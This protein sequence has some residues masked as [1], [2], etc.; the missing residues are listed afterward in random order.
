MLYFHF[1]VVGKHISDYL[2]ID[3]RQL[4]TKLNFNSLFHLPYDSVWLMIEPYEAL[5]ISVNW[6]DPTVIDKCCHLATAISTWYDGFY[7]PNH[8]DMYCHLW[9]QILVPLSHSFGV[10]PY[11]I[12]ENSPSFVPYFRC[13]LMLRSK[14]KHENRIKAF[15]PIHGNS[16]KVFPQNKHSNPNRSCRFLFL[17]NWMEQIF[18]LMFR[19]FE[20][21]AGLICECNTVKLNDSTH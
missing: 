1:S 3:T 8:T 6:L 19:S 14:Q 10:S 15:F 4:L 13:C 5:L 18:L 17:V 7:F 12:R 9:K 20:L 21:L 2:S 11:M 16:L